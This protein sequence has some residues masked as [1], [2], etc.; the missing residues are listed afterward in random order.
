MTALE[1][2]D[3]IYGA[4]MYNKKILL[5]HAGGWSQR[6]P[7]ATILGK[8]F[9]LLPHGS[10]PYQMLDLKLAL[11]WPFVDRI[12]PGVF[13]VCADDFLVYTFES[14][15]DWKVP[16]KGF[17]ALAHPSPIAVGRTHG[18]Y[19]IKNIVDVDTM[20]PVMIKECLEVLQKPTD[21]RMKS[22]GALLKGEVHSFAD[23]I[24]LTG[25][26]VYTDSSFYFGKDIMQKLLSFK[27]SVGSLSCEIDAYGD[28][29]QAVG[30]HATNEYIHLTSNVSQFTANLLHMRQA[31]FDCLND[32]DIHV[33]VLNA[34]AFVHIGTTKELLYHFCQDRLFQNQMAFEKD[35]FN[36][37][38]TYRT[39]NASMLLSAKGSRDNR[40][41]STSACIIHSAIN[42]ESTIGENCVMDYCDFE[43]PVDIEQ[44]CIISNCQLA[45]SETTAEHTRL[46]IPQGIFLHTVP[47]TVENTTKFVTV[48][49]GVDDNLK[50]CV[51]SV[52][53]ES[54]PFMDSNIGHFMKVQGLHKENILPEH[55]WE[56]A[57]DLSVSFNNSSTVPQPAE[58][59]NKVSLWNLKLYPAQSSMTASLEDAVQAVSVG[60]RLKSQRMSG[61][62]FSL[63]E[64]LRLKDV[65]AML[66]FRKSLYEKIKS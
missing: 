2:L 7:S 47:I 17:T 26:V 50:K 35:V 4:E 40:K 45:W 12:E 3:T 53:V 13:L 14:S 55:L 32:S 61:V 58:E 59:N 21:E 39:A 51:S 23:G 54:L 42:K 34:S 9:S 20:V 8:I 6:M 24:H 64:L 25:E 28:F 56:N 60:L 36:A 31:V 66:N 43:L 52:D 46:I 11:Y 27:K 15:R 29:L 33:L 63:A 18:V 62:M 19:V 16:A 30:S 41:I 38:N 5:I 49:F 65:Q 48:F 37:W 44:N 1:F 57:K 10:P 22:H